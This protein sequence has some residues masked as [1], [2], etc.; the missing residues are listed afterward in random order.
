MKK[1]IVLKAVFALLLCFLMTAC[2][3][4]RDRLAVSDPEYAE[5]VGAWFTGDDPW[6]GKLT[7]TIKSIVDG[8]MEWTFTDSFDSSTLYGEMKGTEVTN[9]LVPFVV[10]GRDAGERNTV[11]RYQGM[12]ELKDGAVVM[13][14]ESGGVENRKSGDGS[15]VRT[16]EE[17]AEA[18]SSGR[19]VLER[20]EDSEMTTY[21]VQPGDSLH[22][23]AKRYGVSTKDLAIM[24]QTVIIETARANGYEFDDMIEYAK[25]LFPGEVLVVPVSE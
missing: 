11:F 23:I 22:S 19:I 2:S 15:A 20:P 17:L 7:V 10:Q 25:Y 1:P 4:G 12:M 16:A 5:Y 14:F 9:G 21:T 24:N 6:G 8:K 18:G 3:S 13:T